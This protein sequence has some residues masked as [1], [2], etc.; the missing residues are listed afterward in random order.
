MADSGFF[1][2]R[3]PYYGYEGKLEAYGPYQTSGYPH[4]LS[5]H[6]DRTRMKAVRQLGLPRRILISARL[7]WISG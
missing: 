6:P 1:F 2:D 4:A 5:A 7:V 3:Y